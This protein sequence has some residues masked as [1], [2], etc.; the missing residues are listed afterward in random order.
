MITQGSVKFLVDVAQSETTKSALV[1][2]SQDMQLLGASLDGVVNDLCILPDP[3]LLHDEIYDLCIIF[4]DINVNKM[5]LGLIKNTVAQKI[6]VIKNPKETQD[7][8]SLLELGFVL[9]SEISN[10]NIYSY[11]LKTYNTKRGWNNAEGWA[12]PENFEKFRW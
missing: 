10:K 3:D 11:N 6:L 12:N 8:Q 4:D 1:L 2:T 7:H 5:Q 9:D